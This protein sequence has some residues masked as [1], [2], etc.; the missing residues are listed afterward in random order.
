MKKPN[1]K[2][3]MYLGMKDV[4]PESS[5]LQVAEHGLERVHCFIDSRPFK[6]LGSPILGLLLIEDVLIFM[7]ESG[8]FPRN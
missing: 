4:E 5:H 2:G 8:R 6:H 3:N 1:D 7:N